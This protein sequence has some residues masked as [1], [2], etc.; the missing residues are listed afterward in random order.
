MKRTSL[1]FP[2][3]HSQTVSAG[4]F[5]VVILFLFLFCRCPFSFQFSVPTDPTDV[6]SAPHCFAWNPPFHTHFQKQNN[7][8]ILIPD[9]D[10]LLSS[11]SFIN[12]IVQNQ[13]DFFKNLHCTWPF[14]TR[15][16]DFWLMYWL[17]NW[18][19]CYYFFAST[20]F[21]FNFIYLSWKIYW[22]CLFFYVWFIRR[23]LWISKFCLLWVN[24]LGFG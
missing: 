1:P 9:I 3:P 10:T 24:D 14:S 17:V 16:F 18:S 11:L 15:H 21:I 4:F 6:F 8:L 19:I 12:S 23:K 22:F 2:P 13:L 20:F 5:L 7:F